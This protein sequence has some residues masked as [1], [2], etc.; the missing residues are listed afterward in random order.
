MMQLGFQDGSHPRPVALMTKQKRKQR[1]AHSADGKPTDV[2][3]ITRL[4]GGGCALSMPE[5][6]PAVMIS[7]PG[8]PTTMKQQQM[9]EESGSSAAA[10]SVFDVLS[11]LDDRLVAVLSRGDIRLLRA[12]WLVSQ[13]NGYRIKRRQELEQL[14]LRLD[15]GEKL[16]PLLSPDEAI[17][18]IR[19]GTRC[20]GALSYGW[21]MGGSADPVGARVA[22]LQQTLA[23]LSYIEAIFWECALSLPPPSVL[24]SSESHNGEL[25]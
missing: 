23:E 1:V 2:W 12:S 19:R 4:R 18:L 9:W 25:P 13:P 24:I 20:V 5:Q 17:A 16:G 6:A 21:L 8:Q 10:A 22:L 11:S 7:A 3:L 15:P 14:E